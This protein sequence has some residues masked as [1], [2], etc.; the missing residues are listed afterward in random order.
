MDNG[1]D[2][3]MPGAIPAQEAEAGAR[4][5]LPTLGAQARPTERAA[6][7]P[8]CGSRVATTGGGMTPAR[9]ASLDAHKRRMRAAFFDRP[10]FCTRCRQWVDRA[11]THMVPIGN[12]RGRVECRR[13]TEGA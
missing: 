7:Q 11:G 4:S 1:M 9:R 12:G 13:H 8:G 2:A 3:D 10:V 5:V 6:A